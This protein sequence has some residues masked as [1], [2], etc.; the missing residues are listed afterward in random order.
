MVEGA[1]NSLRRGFHALLSLWPLL[2]V[3]LVETITI[4]VVM[5]GGVALAMIPV[6]LSFDFGDVETWTDEPEVLAES[7]AEWLVSNV[8][9]FAF[10]LVVLTLLVGIAVLIHS[11]FEAGVVA[12]YLDHIRAGVSIPMREAWARFSFDAFVKAAL[13]RGW[14]VFLV[15]NIVWGVA[16][17]VMLIPAGLLLGVILLFRDSPAAIA[18]TCLGLMVVLFVS[19]VASIIATVWAQVALTISAGDRRGPIESSSLAGEMMRARLGVTILTAICVFAAIFGISTVTST[20]NLAL[21]VLAQVPGAEMVAFM[22]Q[23][24]LFLAN[25]VVSTVLGLWSGAVWAAFVASGTTSTR[26]VP[27]S[28]GGSLGSERALVG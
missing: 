26:P 7:I 4:M 16:G 14:S 23:M 19:V 5:L 10:F 25:T 20:F 21:N 22:F 27:G 17:A 6:G 18:F 11:Y 1:I 9:T 24:M 13:S 12:V 28:S 15:Y 8:G 3:R 2:L